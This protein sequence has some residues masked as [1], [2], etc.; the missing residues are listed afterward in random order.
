MMKILVA[1]DH[2]DNEHIQRLRKAFP[3]VEFTQA[4][5]Q[6]A[7]LKEASSADVILGGM[8][9][10]VFAVAKNL[11][12]VQSSG[13]GVER[14]QFPAFI[15]S[16]VILTNASG[17]HNSVSEHALGLI[18]AFGRR[19]SMY[20][21][22]QSEHKWDRREFEPWHGLFI[23]ELMGKVLGIIGLGHIGHE[24]ARKGKCFG[25]TV[26]A[27]KRSPV[28]KPAYVDELLPP[29][30]LGDLLRRSDFVVICVPIT[31][32]THHLIGE[33]E[34]RMMKKNAILIN[35][36][37]GDVI[38]KDS[39]IK[40]LKE[41]WI[42]G[43]GLDVFETEPLPSESELWDFENVIITPHVAGSTPHYSERLYDLF[44]ENLKRFNE[45]RPLINVIDKKIG[46]GAGPYSSDAR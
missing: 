13:A 2:L 6:A 10:E 45:R 46:A 12:W 23:D 15:N 16:K 37:R 42:A 34:L 40:A 36:G 7:I 32:E 8:N 18:L 27:T 26:I 14:F 24:I 31:T 43:A 11:K 44:V 35:I 4:V 29:K 28:S 17:I 19:L 38:E 3:T 1:T 5:D 21:R 39:L 41:R 9:P 33:K 20:I 30:G 22:F 25:M